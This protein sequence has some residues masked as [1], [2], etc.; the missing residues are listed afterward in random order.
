MSATHRFNPPA[1]S[2]ANADVESSYATIAPE[3]FD[4][5]TLADHDYFLA[6][7]AIYQHGLKFARKTRSRDNLTP[8]D[9]PAFRAPLLTPK[10]FRETM[11]RNEE[12]L[13]NALGFY[14]CARTKPASGAANL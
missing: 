8:A 7:L 3:C 11:A 2:E 12:K 5:A 9:F 13:A 6:A 14:F 4:L 10:F 1:H